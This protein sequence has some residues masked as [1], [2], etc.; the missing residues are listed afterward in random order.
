M[1]L[2]RVRSV[3]LSF[4]C[5]SFGTTVSKIDYEISEV[6]YNKKFKKSLLADF[7]MERRQ[8]FDDSTQSANTHCY[9]FHFNSK[10]SWCNLPP[11]HRRLK[12]FWHFANFCLSDRID[13]TPP[14]GGPPAPACPAV[15][16]TDKAQA[17]VTTRASEYAA[18]LAPDS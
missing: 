18:A 3:K 7:S 14:A 5:R 2:S 13:G 9:K 11:I 6:D 15:T 12:K 16:V 1:C 17:T 8:P 10:T 4:H